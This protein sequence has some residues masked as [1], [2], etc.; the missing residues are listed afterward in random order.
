[1]STQAQAYKRAL[2]PFGR[3]QHLSDEDIAASLN[4]SDRHSQAARKG[5][6]RKKQRQI[7]KK[8]EQEK[9]A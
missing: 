3:P 6:A 7:A 5:A 9:Q 2:Y 8:R 1:M 4:V